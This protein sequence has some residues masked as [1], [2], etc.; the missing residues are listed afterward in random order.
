MSTEII[1]VFSSPITA[2]TTAFVALKADAALGK[3]AFKYG[4]YK[5]GNG[6]AYPHAE[7]VR[8]FSERPIGLLNAVT[9]LKPFLPGD[10]LPYEDHRLLILKLR[11]EDLLVVKKYMVS[12]FSIYALVTNVMVDPYAYAVGEDIEVINIRYPA[13]YFDPSNTSS[14]YIKIV[15]IL[16]G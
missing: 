6:G 2:Q 14:Q 15:P 12:E 5:F 13:E 8:S 9:V 16:G 4:G 10:H 3:V 11:A 1:T 7:N